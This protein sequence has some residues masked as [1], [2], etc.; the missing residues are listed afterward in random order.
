LGANDQVGCKEA[1]KQGFELRTGQKG[2]SQAKRPFAPSQTGKK[3][4]LTDFVIKEV[5]HKIRFCE[6]TRVGVEEGKLV[7]VER[8]NTDVDNK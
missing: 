2:D 7:A 5:S 4:V 8:D 6:H 3:N 1:K